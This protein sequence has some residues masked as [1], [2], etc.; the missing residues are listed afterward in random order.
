VLNGVQALQYARARHGNG[1]SGSDLDRIDRQQQLLKNLARKVVGADVLFNPKDLFAFI[2][3]TAQTV[4]MD[5]Q[6]GNI[7][8]YSVGLGLSLRNLDPKAGIVMATVP[9]KGYAPDPNRVEFAAGAPAI[10]AALAQDQPM[11]PLLDKNSASPANDPEAAAAP[12]PAA[13]PA[14]GAEESNRE[15]AEILASCVS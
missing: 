12:D 6:L 3:A 7:D 5:E 4:T 14:G 9:V 15:E 13:P 11:A 10:F 2:S 8:G 1:F